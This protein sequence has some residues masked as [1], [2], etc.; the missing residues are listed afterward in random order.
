M[1]GAAGVL[2]QELGEGKLGRRKEGGFIWGDC[3]RSDRAVT[4]SSELLLTAGVSGWVSCG[5]GLRAGVSLFPSCSCCKPT[6]WSG[7]SVGWKRSG[8][9]VH[10]RSVE[11]M[12][13]QSSR[14]NYTKSS[15]AFYQLLSE[16]QF[17]WISRTPKIC[18]YSML[19]VVL[20]GK[21]FRLTC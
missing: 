14:L 11:K 4:S 15:Y 21:L 2:G 7:T 19:L 16:I 12:N 9:A 17:F 13:Q 3:R 6:C 8:C 5:R 1:I 18:L 10:C 20:S